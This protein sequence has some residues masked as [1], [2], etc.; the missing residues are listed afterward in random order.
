MAAIAS[1]FVAMC[2]QLHHSAPRVAR[3]NKT[4]K[5]SLTF[6]FF[7]FAKYIIIPQDSSGIGPHAGNR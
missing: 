4:Q 7:Y 5:D 3:E 1:F 6:F 2:F